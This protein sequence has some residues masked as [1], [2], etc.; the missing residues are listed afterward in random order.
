MI[1]VLIHMMKSAPILKCKCCGKGCVVLGYQGDEDEFICGH[2]QDPNAQFNIRCAD[3]GRK[4]YLDPVSN[5]C[6][7]CGTNYGRNHKDC[8]QGED[9]IDID[10][11]PSLISGH[12]DEFADQENEAINYF[13]N[14]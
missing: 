7:D 10:M 12:P 2:C 4:V 5:L 1:N 6:E 11:D 9:G 14:R 3:C 8:E 13:M